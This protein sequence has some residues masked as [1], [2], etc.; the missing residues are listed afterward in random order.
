MKRKWRV[1]KIDGPLALAASMVAKVLIQFAWDIDVETVVFEGGLD[2]I[3]GQIDRCYRIIPKR[4]DEY[5]GADFYPWFNAAI[6]AVNE[7]YGVEIIRKGDFIDFADIHH[8]DGF[9]KPNGNMTGRLR[10]TRN[11]KRKTPF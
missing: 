10:L 7:N 2:E 5:L 4:K 8:I 6:Q 1:N 9:L 11:T 3:E